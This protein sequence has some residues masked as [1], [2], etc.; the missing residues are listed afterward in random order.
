MTSPAR[1]A[2]AALLALA[3]ACIAAPGAQAASFGVQNGSFQTSLG[4]AGAEV[5]RQAAGHPTSLSVAFQLNEEGGQPLGELQRLAL[6]LPL[7]LVL[8]PQAPGAQCEA[9]AF[10]ALPEPQCPAES[11]V[12]TDE[13]TIY[14][15]GKDV[16]V[17][18][19]VYD[20]RQPA[21]LASDFGVYVPAGGG[22]PEEHLF[23]Q[24]H[25]SASDYHEQLAMTLPSG[26]DLSGSV[27]KL[28][29]AHTS[30][31]LTLP[32]VCAAS[33]IWGLTVQAVGGA[34]E[35]SSFESPGAQGCE[36]VPFAARLSSTAQTSAY[37]QPTGL[38]VVASLPQE[39]STFSADI[40]RE[41]LTLPE[42]LTL[43]LP[44]LQGLQGCTAA[45]AAIGQETASACPATAQIGTAAIAT[46]ILPEAL[47]G[48][49]Y[50]AGETG[51]APG[52][53]GT[54][55]ALY[56]IY[57]VLESARYGTSLRLQGTIAAA[58]GDGQLEVSFD[59]AP[60]LPLSELSLDLGASSSLLANPLS[61]GEGKLEAALTPYTTLLA[62]PALSV[63]LASTGC[64]SPLPF[65]PS[66][67]AADATSKA[68]AGT[69]FTLALA[70][71]PGQQYLANFRS[72]LP[73]GLVAHIPAAQACPEAQASSGT[74]APASEVGIGS[75]EAGAGPAPVAL[76]G[77]LFL[78]APFGGAPY[79]LALDVPVS[80]GP[81][82]LGEV[83]LRVKLAL[84]PFSGQLVLEGG[85]PR[86]VQGIALRARRISISFERSGFIYN[87]TDCRTFSTF[88]TLS[89]FT[90]GAAES[91]TRTLFS[92]LAI[93]GCGA[94]AFRPAVAARSSASG[95]QAAG[96]NLEANLDVPA[97]DA[98]VRSL[99]L[100]LPRQFT[101][102][103]STLAQA[104]AE[105]T[106]DQNPQACPGGS[107]V[108][109]ASASTPLLGAKLAGP[110]ILVLHSQTNLPELFV[111]LNGDG[112]RLI[113]AG[114]FRSA[115]GL[116]FL[117]FGSDPDLP[118]SSLKLNLPGGTHSA[119]AF[120]PRAGVCPLPLTMPTT[121]TAWSGSSI[122]LFTAVRP[123]GCGVRIVGHKVIG[124]VAYLTIQTFAAG[125][126]S[127]SGPDLSTSYRHLSSPKRAI[128]LLVEL[129]AHARASRRP[130]RIRLRVGF[131]PAAKGASSA[132]FITVRFH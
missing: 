90:P 93:S 18:A 101:L 31:L 99:L 123:L 46:P 89:G 103:S 54:A 4:G 49:I 41:R 13:L 33:M 26:L 66:Q 77:R 75:I 121:I 72:V 11:R 91:P 88:T 22:V 58:R 116:T 37:E 55:Q 32:S 44:G 126:I 83:I 35:S 45:Q 71:T 42:R 39:G 27:L 43:N 23:L 16:Q 3:L 47:T 67:S 70:R 25:I 10:E 24:G 56:P 48:G 52:G 12:G 14:S 110:A 30:A 36:T 20:L 128:A 131:V 68:G 29:G 40:A 127:A 97:G 2:F 117:D 9:S 118:I 28:E 102:R 100:Q 120:V 65:A 105:S 87:P 64:P 63:T 8:D 57:L 51:V 34:S 129:G 94:L 15:A 7:G 86:I 62:A 19:P 17:S 108:G 73:R 95:A 122:K 115:G 81:F 74:C 78:T 80:A 79:G 59:E 130:L 96:A 38:Q 76:P 107:F 114:S 21:G 50:L 82:K 119:L 109:G 84:D 53:A 104:C 124:N 61:C 98:R 113:L 85:L 69:T 60:P 1:I 112:V 132:A 106:F 5:F 92:P 111:V 6:D 125:R